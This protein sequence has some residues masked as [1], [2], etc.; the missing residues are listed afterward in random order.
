M[1]VYNEQLTIKHKLSTNPALFFFDTKKEPK[2]SLGVV[3]FRP[4]TL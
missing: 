3:N 2:S 1:I 4:R